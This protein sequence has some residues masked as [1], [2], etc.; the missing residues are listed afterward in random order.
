MQVLIN[1]SAMSQD[2]YAL[3]N[4]LPQ[5]IQIPAMSRVVFSDGYQF[6]GL[7][8]YVTIDGGGTDASY[9]YPTL[10]DAIMSVPS[11]ALVGSP[12][13]CSDGFVFI[14]SDSGNIV[15]LSGARLD[16]YSSPLAMDKY[17]SYV[18][19]Y[20]NMIATAQEAQAQVNRVLEQ[21]NAL[22]AEVQAMAPTQRE[23]MLALTNEVD[24][25]EVLPAVLTFRMPFS[26]VLTRINAF[27]TAAPVGSDLVVAVKVGPTVIQTIR[28]LD[29]THVLDMPAVNA[30]IVEGDIISFDITQVGSSVPGIGLKVTLVGTYLNGV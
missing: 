22:H 29:G 20:A 19:T 28:I 16:L 9:S 8:A 3:V 17:V 13:R 27:C 11:D 10:R 30:N 25:I 7:G 6:Q 4:G 23:F 26:M 21:V 15:T 2:V 14:V 5:V 12:V 1:R 24:N 18:A